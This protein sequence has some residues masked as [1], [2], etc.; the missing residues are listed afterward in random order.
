MEWVNWYPT[1]ETEGFDPVDFCGQLPEIIII[2]YL[3]LG[4]LNNQ[5]QPKSKNWYSVF[6]LTDSTFS[7][8]LYPILL[9]L[10]VDVCWCCLWQNEQSTFFLRYSSKSLD[11]SK[12]KKNLLL[13]ISRSNSEQKDLVVCCNNL[14]ILRNNQELLVNITHPLHM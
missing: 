1:W 3:H 2:Y 10:F 6:L 14:I 12:S 4:K 8:L 13:C 7:C 5:L 11:K 9:F